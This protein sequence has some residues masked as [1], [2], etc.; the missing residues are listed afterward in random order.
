MT[1]A[2]P[3]KTLKP[4]YGALD[5]SWILTVK[6]IKQELDQC[7]VMNLKSR[8][9]KIFDKLNILAMDEQPAIAIK[10]YIVLFPSPT[11]REYYLP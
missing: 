1:P 8:I 11:A 3:L 7:L 9:I 5:I 2:D 10:P 6:Q 4:A